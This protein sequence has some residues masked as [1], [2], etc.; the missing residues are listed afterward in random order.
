MPV[1]KGLAK[2]GDGI[3]TLR[4]RRFMFDADALEKLTGSA[5][6]SSGKLKKELGFSPKRHLRDSLPEVIGRGKG[7]KR[8]FTRI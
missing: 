4:G 6:Y 5:W 8:G 7:G 1:L 2:I 3:G